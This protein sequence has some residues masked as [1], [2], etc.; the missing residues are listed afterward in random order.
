MLSELQK[1][2]CSLKEEK[3]EYQDEYCLFKISTTGYGRQL[4]KLSGLKGEKPLDASGPS[5]SVG[6]FP[7]SSLCLTIPA[8]AA[9]CSPQNDC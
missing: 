8:Q 2:N 9:I 1:E 3:Y 7:R 6:W 5:L 4:S